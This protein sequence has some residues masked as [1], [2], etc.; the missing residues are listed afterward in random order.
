M[1]GEPD[2]F[3]EQPGI[4]DSAAVLRHAGTLRLIHLDDAS[5]LSRFFKTA[6]RVVGSLKFMT[7]STDAGPLIQ[8]VLKDLADVVANIRPDQFT[9]PTPCAD[10]DVATLR[11]HVLAWV[12]YF[13]AAFNDPDGS[14]ERPDPKTA[15]A[16]GDPQAAAEVVRMAAA[17]I[18]TA[19]DNG[20]AERSVLMVQTSMPGDSMLRMA[21]W[22]Y[23]THGN[24]LASAT[25]QPWDPPVAAAENA[26]E[27]APNMLTDE[28]RGEGKDF[29]AI[30]PVP[31]DA[32][33]LDRLLGFSGR[34]PHW[35]P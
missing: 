2:S 22:E 16:P 35:K 12:T 11:T 7:T 34:D 33:A 19:V 18:A 10:F 13:G 14:T 1:P 24:D 20:V 32:S 23:L 17:R 15:V 5:Q 21:L 3:L 9:D 29:G 25:G 28:Y 6:G 4:D 27:F 30:V 8:P 26:L 31:D